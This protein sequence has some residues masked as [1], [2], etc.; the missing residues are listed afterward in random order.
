MTSLLNGE[1][2]VCCGRPQAARRAM[3]GVDATNALALSVPTPSPTTI[4]RSAHDRPEEATSAF[5]GGG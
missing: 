3:S 2:P 5:T 4:V 1:S